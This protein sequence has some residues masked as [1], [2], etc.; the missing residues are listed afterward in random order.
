LKAE[1]TI[2]MAQLQA[3]LFEA[4]E[5]KTHV[6]KVFFQCATKDRNVVKVDGFKLV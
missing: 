4:L 3:L 2:L 1:E 6:L 5:N